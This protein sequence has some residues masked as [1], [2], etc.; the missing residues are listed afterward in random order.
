MSIL[1]ALRVQ[2]AE[3]KSVQ[4]L[5]MLPQDQIVRMAQIG[6]IPADVLPVVISEKARMEKEMA[7]RKALMAQGGGQQPTI[8][9]QAMATNAQAEA[10]Q[11][12]PSIAQGMP[13]GIPQAPQGP[14]IPGATPTPELEA[15]GVSA[16]PTGQMFNQQNFAGGGIV[17]FAGEG[18]SDVS[19]ADLLNQQ[20]RQDPSFAGMFSEA[21]KEEELPGFRRRYGSLAEA[22]AEASQARAPLRQLSPEEQALQEYLKKVGPRSEADAT[23]SAWMRALEAGLGIMGGTSPY[24]LTNIGEGSKAAIRGFGEDVKERRKGELA[25]MAAAAEQA[26]KARQEKLED[27]AAGERLFKEDTEAE[28][29]NAVL[30]KTTDY[31]R[32]Y[33]N[34]LPKVMK[35]LKTK[36]PNDPEVMAETA[37][38]VDLSIGAAAAKIEQKGVEDEGTRANNAAK[39]AKD[40]LKETTYQ[41]ELIKAKTPEAQN[42]IRLR[43]LNEERRAQGLGPLGGLPADFGGSAA[44]A[45]SQ[46]SALP[47]AAVSQLKEG[48]VTTFANGQKW[49]LQNGKPKQVQ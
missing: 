32:R 30:N 17:A 49:T 43:V 6:E 46:A 3:Q 31:Q 35:D 34:Y 45:S 24:A 5:A 27:V 48:F 14:S 41:L 13:Q 8:L 44:P 21:K 4:Q 33:N 12:I 28:Y 29:R 42:A 9:E 16:L 25:S 15:I 10:Q 18:R 1:D 22:I 19:L 23:Q 40:K 26:R 37:R 38:R 20:Q 2:K 47:P 39:L 11:G 7:N 36:D